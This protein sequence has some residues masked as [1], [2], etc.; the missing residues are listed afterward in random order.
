AFL[1]VAGAL[2]LFGPA[3]VIAAAIRDRL[4]AELGLWSSVGVATTKFIAKLASEAAKPSASLNGPV[5][6]AGVVVVPPGDELSFLHPLPIDALWGVGPATAERL[7]RMGVDTV[8]DLAAVPPASLTAALGKAAGQH[9]HD[10]SWG[11]DGR[12]VEP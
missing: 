7:R 9:L 8:G 4:R 1:D 11:R 2:R 10:L 3:P 6:G 5:P 12:A